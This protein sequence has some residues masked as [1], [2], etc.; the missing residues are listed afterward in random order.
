MKPHALLLATL[1]LVVARAAAQ[2]G[3]CAPHAGAGCDDATC[4]AAVCALDP[5]CCSV[6]W[7]AR[8][9]GEASVLCNTCRPAPGCTLPASNQSESEACG[10]TVDDP[11]GPTGGAPRPLP[12]GV[13]ASG[14]L[15]STANARDVD[16]FEV[17]LAAPARLQVEIWSAGPIGAVIVDDACPPTVHADS[18]DGCPAR[19]EACLPAG[20]WR[21]AV[22]P[23][24]FEPMP[25][26]DPHG[27]YAVRATVHPCNPATPVNDRCDTPMPA[28]I[29]LV[30]FDGS[31]AS[32]EPAWLPP[33]CDEG[34]GLALSHDVWF[35]FTAPQD[36][37]YRFST[38]GHAD[39][40]A[41][42]AL[43]D[44]CGGSVLACNDDACADGG[45]TMQAGLACG[46]T[47]LLRVGGWGHGA[48]G[49]LEI[50]PSLSGGCACPGDLDGTGEIDA[51]DAAVL[52]LCFGD[53][54]GP[55]DLDADGEVGSADLGLLLLLHGP[56]S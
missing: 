53:P 26:G 36:D 34:A 51:S 45:A 25:C 47:V 2:S 13:V 16:W 22:R 11:C 31:D 46:Q 5:F 43:Y 1:T 8:C 32:T 15:W 37:V 54:G 4:A 33:W 28:T 23:L 44:H 27:A 29:G 17:T 40:D 12:A 42:L 24:L 49:A 35:S 21:V 18:T 9:A 41:R 50:L 10:D 6:T 3:C 14:A 48:A 7:D 52:L 55:A 38:C 30:P 19:C 39:F 56:C 20:T